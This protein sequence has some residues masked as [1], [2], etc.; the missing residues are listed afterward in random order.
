MQTDLPSPLQVGQCC[1]SGIPPP[2]LINSQEEREP[3][4][5][6][7]VAL[8]LPASRCAWHPAASSILSLLRVGVEFLAAHQSSKAWVQSQV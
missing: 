1:G 7:L 5:I 3:L 2:Y 6:K 8:T 4:P